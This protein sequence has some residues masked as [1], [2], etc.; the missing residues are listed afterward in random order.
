MKGVEAGDARTEVGCEG[1]GGWKETIV[2]SCWWPAH[3][4]LQAAGGSVVVLQVP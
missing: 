4:G 2:A 3:A 1:E